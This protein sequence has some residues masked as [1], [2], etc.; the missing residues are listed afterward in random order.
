MAQFALET[1]PSAISQP[2]KIRFGLRAGAATLQRTAEIELAGHG[3]KAFAQHEIDD[4]L[5]STITVFERDLFGQNLDA[6]DRFGWNVA[7]F[8]KA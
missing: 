8:G 4:T 3:S 7:D 5:I 6:L 2:Q 1:E